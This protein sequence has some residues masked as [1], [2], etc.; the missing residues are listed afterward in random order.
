MMMDWDELESAYRERVGEKVPLA[1][2]IEEHI[3]TSGEM[4]GCISGCSASSAT[5]WVEDV[6]AGYFEG[7]RRQ[8]EKRR[9]IAQWWADR[10]LGFK[11]APCERPVLRWRKDG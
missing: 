2:R 10:R 3:R 1:P 9:L 11:S 5:G 8:A 7:E 6:V 4:A